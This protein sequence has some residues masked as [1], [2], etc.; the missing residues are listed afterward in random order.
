MSK[1]TTYVQRTDSSH[2]GALLEVSGLD[3]S[4]RHD[5]H[6]STVVRDLSLTLQAG[7]RLAIVGE[8]GSG[9]TMTASAI[10][11]LLPPRASVTSGSVRLLG[12]DI[13]NLPS[14]Q[15][16]RYR[17]QLMGLVP[18]DPMSSLNPVHTIGW[19]L[20]EALT[21]HAA[22]NRQAAA[23]R[24]TELLEMVGI[25][26]PQTRLKAYPHEFSGGMRQ[27][28]LIAMAL[29]L[30]PRL[31]IAD[32]STT[33]L[34]VTVQAQVLDLIDA[35]AADAG[36]AVILITHDL[37]V[38]AGRTDSLLVM[39]NGQAVEAG[40]T[41]TVLANPQAL[42]TRQLL[43]AS[44]HFHRPRKSRFATASSSPTGTPL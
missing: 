26:D 14:A 27:R 23:T 3:V 6:S 40:P 33:A 43:A 38:A 17:G 18:Q 29:A 8:S 37:A 24:A 20:R 5:T 16:R 19:Q 28:V 41:A 4:I 11:G 21:A 10:L 39:R 25:S 12:E 31:L 22:V 9:K 36:S 15:M 35:L 7:E 2:D 13:T 42:Y 32:E 30:R 44:P 1:Q 34:D